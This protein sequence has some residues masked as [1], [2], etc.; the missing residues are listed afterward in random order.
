MG[1]VVVVRCMS[2]RR[3]MRGAGV[4]SDYHIARFLGRMMAGQQ[5]FGIV[6]EMHGPH[7]AASL[8]GAKMRVC[9]AMRAGICMHNL[10]TILHSTFS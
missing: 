3:C 9:M 1:S 6:D 8:L 2:Y 4:G 5:P 7:A 10:I